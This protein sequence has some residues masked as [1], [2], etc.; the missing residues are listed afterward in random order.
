MVD[1]RFVTSVIARVSPPGAVGVAQRQG[2]GVDRA[3]RRHRIPLA[4]HLL[5]T[6]LGVAP[7]TWSSDGGYPTVVW[8]AELAQS[9]SETR[10]TLWNSLVSPA[11]P[12]QRALHRGAEEQG[13][14]GDHRRAGAPARGGTAP[15]R[16]RRCAAG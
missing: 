10:T 7:T 1:R 6:E 2:D 3:G 8:K 15:R 5:H 12:G 4:A 16:P 14:L 13:T 11:D 9:Y